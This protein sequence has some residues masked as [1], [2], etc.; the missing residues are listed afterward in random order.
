MEMRQRT[1]FSIEDSPATPYG[2]CGLFDLCS[3]DDV[4][5]LTL[6]KAD[7]L[8]DW[9]GFS[10]STVCEIRRNFINWQGPEGTAAGAPQG[11]YL[12]DPC[13]EPITYEYGTCDWIVENFGRLRARGPIREANK[14][15]R[16][17]ENEPRWRLDGRRVS[18]EL[19]WDLLF[20]AEILLQDLRRF[21]I[22]GNAVTGGL[23]D[24]LQQ[25]VVDGY[26]DTTGHR[27][28]RMDSLVVDWN[29][30]DMNGTGGGA[31]TWNGNAV[32]GTPN[33]VDML[34]DV[35]R[36]I[37]QLIMWTPRLNRPLRVGDVI[38]VMPTFLTR[39]LLD[40]Y[41]CWSV[42]DGQEYNEVNMNTHEARRFRAGLM[43]GMF[44]FGKIY[45]DGFEIPL[46]GWDWD[47]MINGPTTGDIYM[48]T[49]QLGG[50]KLLYYEYL[51]MR[52][53]ETL[54]GKLKPIETGRFLQ[55]LE[56]DET[57]YSTRLE[58]KP[59]IVSWAPWTN[60]R[61][62]DVVCQ[63]PTGPMSPDPTQTSYFPESSFSVAECP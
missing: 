28:E 39:C 17:C 15:L 14:E 30:N 25:L 50:V 2:C 1:D 57:C 54:N 6:Q 42:C 13:A 62:Q 59:R 16:L 49:G 27:C 3:E 37:R 22:T 32:N 36:R 26:T 24:G 53:S 33:L 38:L 19:E 20:A 7:P 40:A 51:D 35:F 60:A 41:T 45:L 8:L 61:F 56:S 48:L 18:S 31:I 58:I 29:G 4:L 9:L 63:V 52:T 47:G 12:A 11:T 46:L 21:T 5:S 10:P 23:Y 34:L 55:W 44:N 43:G